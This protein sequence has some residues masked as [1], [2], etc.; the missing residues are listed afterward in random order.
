MKQSEFV[1]KLRLVYDTKEDDIL[2]SECFDLVSQYV[3]REIAGEPV[4]DQMPQV[5][6]HIE[7]CGVCRDEYVVLR[8]LALLDAQEES[9]KA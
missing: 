9:H 7:H 8:D 1:R 6:Y 2:C 4:A 5:K 3:D